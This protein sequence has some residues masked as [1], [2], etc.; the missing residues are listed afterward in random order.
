MEKL[1]FFQ[2]EMHFFFDQGV[3]FLPLLGV[4]NAGRC[5]W[6]VFVGKNFQL[7]V[8]PQG[9]FTSQVVG[10]GI[11]ERMLLHPR[12]LQFLVPFQRRLC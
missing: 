10:L 8:P 3:F 12:Y 4:R 2:E 6:C 5:V 9:L 11:S 7:D 1:S